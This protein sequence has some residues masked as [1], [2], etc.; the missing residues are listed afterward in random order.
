MIYHSLFQSKIRK[1]VTKFVIGALRVKDIKQGASMKSLENDNFTWAIPVRVW[2]I[3]LIDQ[4]FQ[5]SSMMLT[6]QVL[7]TQ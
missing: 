6:N 2:Q 7:L 4:V 5:C 1:D 3:F